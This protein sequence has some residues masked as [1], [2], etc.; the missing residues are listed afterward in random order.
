[1]VYTYTL[2]LQKETMMMQRSKLERN[3]D[4]LEILVRAHNSSPKKQ[5]TLNHIMHKLNISQNSM[6]EHLIFL[7][8]QQL[9]EE[10]DFGRGSS[11]V[12]T[13]R[14]LRVLMVVTPIIEKVRKTAAV[15]H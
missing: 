15:L 4:I 11:F 2:T 1:M 13:E 7:L 9:I 10:Q 8:Q 14:G 3:L 12:I 6:K 5:M